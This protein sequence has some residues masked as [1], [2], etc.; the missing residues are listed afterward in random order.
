M[1]PQRLHTA[2]VYLLSIYWKTAQSTGNYKV[3]A[4]LLKKLTLESPKKKCD[5]YDIFHHAQYF[6]FS[7][8]N[9]CFRPRK[10]NYVMIIFQ[11]QILMS[12]S[13][14]LWLERGGYNT[15]RSIAGSCR[16]QDGLWGSQF[17]VISFMA[18]FWQSS[19]CLKLIMFFL[20]WICKNI[21]KLSKNYIL[22]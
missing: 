1:G 18:I 3:H 12:Y 14:I 4:H 5:S 7:L 2:F 21:Q 10:Y 15:H 22:L 16:K 13:S 8:S 19:I 17:P 20:W 6:Q 9:N 11:V